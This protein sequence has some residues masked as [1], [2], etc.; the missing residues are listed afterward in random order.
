[1]AIISLPL[2]MGWA[3]LS[4]P[5][6]VL[7][8]GRQRRRQLASFASRVLL[9]IMG[10]R[11]E[12]EGLD[13][14]PEDSCIVVANHASYL[15]G[16]ILTALLPPR[17]SFV[18]KREMASVPLVGLLLRRL[19]SLFVDRS[20]SLRGRGDSRTIL[21]RA[22]R[23]DAIGMFPE[24]TFTQE[25]GLLP[26]RAGAFVT[27]VRTGMTV[28]PVTIRGSRQALPARI[29]L[30]APGR[31][32]VIIHPDVPPRGKSRTERLRLQQEARR[33]ILSELPEP[34]RERDQS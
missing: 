6:I 3:L 13:R 4:T 8:P 30:P 17:F 5:V 10:L 15:D 28:V 24:G 12:L 2:G 29:W 27:A 1:M 20:G 23:G 16:I 22:A 32:E 9:R 11:L 7:A 21:Q 19:G 18:I 14:M 25:P 34:C 26:F 33:R 31:I